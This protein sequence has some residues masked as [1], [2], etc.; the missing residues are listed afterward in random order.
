[1]SY[2]IGFDNTGLE[3]REQVIRMCQLMDDAGYD[4]VPVLTYNTANG[5]YGEECPCSE[6][7]WMGF[8]E[9][10]HLTINWRTEMLFEERIKLFTMKE[11]E[12]ARESAEIWARDYTIAEHN[13]RTYA[14]MVKLIREEIGRRMNT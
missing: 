1:M 5:M 11:L 10:A 7:E 8:L 3:T 12:A 4:V 2:Q 9:Q 6:Q 14:D 13:R